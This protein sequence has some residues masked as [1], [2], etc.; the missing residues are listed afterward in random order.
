VFKVLDHK[1]YPYIINAQWNNVEGE[2]ITSITETKEYY[3]K[4]KDLSSG[5]P[6]DEGYGVTSHLGTSS[7]GNGSPMKTIASA[8][9]VGIPSIIFLLYKFTP[10]RTWI[11]PRIRTSKIELNNFFQGSNELQSH[12]YNLDTSYMDFKRFNIAYQSR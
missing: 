8:S 5:L 6:K 10:I 11:D 9:L 1:L 7:E 3:G 12:D 4:D 2:G